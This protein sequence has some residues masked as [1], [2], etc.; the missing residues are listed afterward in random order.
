[1]TEVVVENGYR[2]QGVLDGPSI[3]GVGRNEQELGLEGEATQGNMD[4]DGR[5]TQE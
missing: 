1:M 2:I 3:D 5:L 4:L